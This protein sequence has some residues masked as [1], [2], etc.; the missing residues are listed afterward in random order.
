MLKIVEEIERGLKDYQ[1]MNKAASTSSINKD[2]C[3]FS[4]LLI[5]IV[6][7]SCRNIILSSIPVKKK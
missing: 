1:R 2:E 6:F 4:L 3:S 7:D 5:F